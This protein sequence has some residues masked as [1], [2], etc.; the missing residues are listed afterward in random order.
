MPVCNPATKTCG[1]CSL[2]T[3]CP[4]L[5]P[6]CLPSGAC[7]ECS[8][9]NASR[10]TGAKPQCD[11]AAHVCV[12]CRTSADCSGATPVCSATTK[13]CVGCT[14]DANCSGAVPACEPSGACG[15]CSA[16]NKTQCTGG[17]PACST[18]TGTCV[19]CVTSTDCPVTAPQC[20]TGT[21]VCSCPGAA[22]SG[23]DS[24]NDGITDVRERA[25]GTDPNDADSDDDGVI[26]GQ[27]PSF[28]QDSDGDG[29]INALDPDSDN[30]GL[31]DGTELGLGC[32][33]AATN[34]ARGHCRPDAD[35]GATKTDP[36]LAD[37]DGGGARDGSEDFNL[38]GAIDSGETDPTAGHGADDASVVDT[39]GDGLSDGLEKFLHSSPE[40]ADS[41]DDGV[42]DGEEANPSEDVDSDGLVDVLDVDSDNDALFDGT[43]V[44]KGC[45]GAGT[46]AAAGHCIPDGDSAATVTSMILADT[47]RGG[48]RDGSEDANRNGVKDSG[49]QDP[50]AGHGSDDGSVVDTDGDGLSD[51]TEV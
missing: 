50:T 21:G 19:G 37:T 27:E 29:A 28:D 3:D 45:S 47:D 7:G 39:D 14:S 1:G 40:D 36:L 10:C 30:D 25:I 16:T 23:A 12:G 11:T 38:N 42:P 2:D 34:V 31:Y 9:T 46:N 13:T 8:A 41:D 15:Q 33:N 43:E 26:D 49:E 17:T 20:T 18:S 35:S 4:A 6:A 44:G 51:A 5:L 48:A 22:G 32:S 24:D